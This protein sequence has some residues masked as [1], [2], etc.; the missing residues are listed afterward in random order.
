MPTADA[1][2][3]RHSAFPLGRMLLLALTAAAYATLGVVAAATD[4]AAPL[5]VTPPPRFDYRR[6]FKPP[7]FLLD[8]TI[9]YFQP[10]TNKVV[11]G[12][13]FVRLAMS[14]PNRNG[15]IWSTLPV[16]YNEWV[17][18][19]VFSIYGRG[20]SGGEGIVLWLSDAPHL[21][22]A[23]PDPKK[24]RQAQPDPMPPAHT[25]FYGH[26][27]SFKGRA[28]VFD[29]SDVALHRSNPFIYSISNDGSKT[30]SDF[31]NYMSP[32][33][34]DG[35]CFREFRNT[36]VPVHARLSY[37][38]KT[39]S[40]EVDIRQLGAGYTNCF[41][42]PVPSIPTGF[43]VGI[44]AA[45]DAG[46]TDDHDIFSLEVFEINAKPH[47]KVFRPNEKEDIAKG[48][49]FAMDDQL[50]KEVKE[51]QEKVR[52]VT[53]AEEVKAG[54]EEATTVGVDSISVKK[55]E[56]NQAHIVESLNTILK[57]VSD[58]TLGTNTQSTKDSTSIQPIPS[59]RKSPELK[60]MLQK[61]T[62]KIDD[63]LV[64]THQI[65]KQSSAN[66]ALSSNDAIK[67]I[68][69]LQGQSH[70]SALY[71]ALYIFASLAGVACILLAYSFILKNKERQAKKFI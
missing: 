33:V 14:I 18:Q 12:P 48:K 68:Q 24:T 5:P 55:I 21:G 65:V 51:A 13:D 42:I 32:Q 64:Q 15:G 6:S 2:T 3:T 37:I 49:K 36:A 7:Y 69:D 53:K 1:A 66:L 9:P 28:I 61:M 67:Q 31:A 41:S 43:H 11:Y 45:T 59:V 54:K 44:S 63:K 22:P 50:R 20:T 58:V 35:A 52:K 71:Y 4:A 16:D 39:L 60:D 46:G 27:A 62:K 10:T 30:I 47:E 56:E 70:S 17:V 40:L 8:Q 34:H 29:T 57:K 23:P 38:N 26:D 25:N 19:L